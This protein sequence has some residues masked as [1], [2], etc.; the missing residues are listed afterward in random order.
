MAIFGSLRDIDTFKIISKELVNDVISQQIGYYKAVLKDTLSNLYGESLN[1]SFIGPILLNCLIERGDF[2]APVDEF[3]PDVLRD[4]TFRF[5]RDD[6]IQA[7]VYPEIGDVVMY[8]ELY[9]QVDNVNENQLIV[10]KDNN[11]SYS[12]GLENF[13]S[14]YSVILTTHYTRGDKLGITQQRL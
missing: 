4:V 14:D 9:Y 10:G 6:M 12:D 8:N 7:N 5:L 2:T 13:G 1:K 3:G 11:Y